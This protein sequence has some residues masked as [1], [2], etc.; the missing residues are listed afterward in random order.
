MTTPLGPTNTFV[1]VQKKDPHKISEFFIPKPQFNL[2]SN[3]TTSFHIR[4][5]YSEDNLL[6]CNCQNL[7]KVYQD[8]S[9]GHC[10]KDNCIIEMSNYKSTVSYQ[11][12]QSKEVFKG[13]KFLR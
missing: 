8:S 1:L 7:V 3:N 2:S 12:Y 13:F 4:L 5:R 9:N 11:W 6:I 10:K